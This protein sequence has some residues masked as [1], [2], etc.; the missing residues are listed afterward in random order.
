M[1][2]YISYHIA[3]PLDGP[4][5]GCGERLCIT[6]Y[7]CW[8][9]VRK[10]D[11]KRQKIK[12]HVTCHL[13]SFGYKKRKHI[14]LHHITMRQKPLTHSRRLG[15]QQFPDLPAGSVG[16]DWRPWAMLADQQSL[17]LTSC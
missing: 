17:L 2:Y 1:S 13:T 3:D 12:Q 16:W 8:S 10:E 14:I 5:I 4:L 11:E 15:A 6:L 9:A 7:H